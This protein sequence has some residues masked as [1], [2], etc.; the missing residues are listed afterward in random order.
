MLFRLSPPCPSLC[1]PPAPDSGLSWPVQPVF[2]PRP[3]PFA[4]L[5]C[6]GVENGLKAPA[7]V[8]LRLRLGV[9]QKEGAQNMI[10]TNTAYK[11]FNSVRVVATRGAVESVPY[12]YLMECLAVIFSAIGALFAPRTPP[13]TTRP[14]MKAFAFF[15]PTRLIP[16]SPAKA[17]AKIVSGSSPRPTAA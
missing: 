3:A 1:V 4:S 12:D 6:R 17:T 15:R 10:T 8:R 16:T 9:T 2:K 5:P 11:P 14:P 13:G 7:F